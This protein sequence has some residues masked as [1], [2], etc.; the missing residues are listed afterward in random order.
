MKPTS[1]EFLDVP[2]RDEEV[3]SINQKPDA[4][5]DMDS[6][7]ESDENIEPIPVQKDEN[8]DLP[9]SN[10][11]S[12]GPSRQPAALLPSRNAGNS[13]A[14]SSSDSDVA[15]ARPTKKP[16]H[17]TVSSDDSSEDETKKGVGRGGA[18]KRG[19]RQPIK[20]GGKRF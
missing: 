2:M 12:S 3:P 15:P 18:A 13:K 14:T 6:A 4:T 20:R 17:L 11:P 10:S 9:L 7:T 1:P 19:T 8:A 16:K 5:N